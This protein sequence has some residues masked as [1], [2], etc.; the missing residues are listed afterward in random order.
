MNH[1]FKGVHWEL[2]LIHFYIPLQAQATHLS[3]TACFV[4]PRAQTQVESFIFFSWQNFPA[5]AVYCHASKKISKSLNCFVSDFRRCWGHIALFNFNY[6]CVHSAVLRTEHL[7][8][9]Q[10]EMQRLRGTS[11]RP[12]L[13]SLWSH[14]EDS[15]R[16]AHRGHGVLGAG[17]GLAEF[18]PSRMVQPCLLSTSPV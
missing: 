16:G 17:M 12:P 5:V 18:S 8:P 6:E 2:V 15:P 4:F 14:G 7:E 11:S 3:C 1:Q 10:A 9:M 13:W